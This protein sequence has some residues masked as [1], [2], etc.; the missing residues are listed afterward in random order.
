MDEY[1][2]RASILDKYRADLAK[3]KSRSPFTPSGKLKEIGDPI[4][5]DR[6]GGR[7]MEDQ[8]EQAATEK[9]EAKA[10]EGVRGLDIQ[11]ALAKIESRKKAISTKA[12]QMVK[13]GR[14]DEKSY[15]SLIQEHRNLRARQEFFKE[16]LSELGDGKDEAQKTVNAAALKR[17]LAK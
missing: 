3:A 16:A 6:L 15:D 10:G 2:S 7:L 14:G 4:N 17:E 8:A 12:A 11:E 5:P 1:Q 13:E 9:A